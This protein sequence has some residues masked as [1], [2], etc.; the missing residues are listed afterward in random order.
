MSGAELVFS[1]LIISVF[2]LNCFC[3][4]VIDDFDLCTSWR[5]FHLPVIF[6]TA[7][8]HLTTEHAI[9]LQM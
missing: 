2:L 7:H 9:R 1:L 3:S 6:L 8:W 5:P 4:A